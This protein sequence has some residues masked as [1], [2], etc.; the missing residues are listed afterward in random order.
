M[1]TPKNKRIILRFN[2]KIGLSIR[3]LATY[4]A[5][6]PSRDLV[7]TNKEQAG[8]LVGPDLDFYTIRDLFY[9]L[10]YVECGI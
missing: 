10:K 4:R 6:R 3:Y 8:M 7:I 9:E 5:S 2:V 1:A